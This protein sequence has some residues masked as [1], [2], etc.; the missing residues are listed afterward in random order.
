MVDI[1]FVP[2]EAWHI[3]HVA[4]HMRAEDVHEVWEMGG[5]TPREALDHSLNHHGKAWT[6]LF[7]GVPAAIFG[8]IPLSILSNAAIA[9]L[10]GTDALA[11]HWRA[12]ARV[13]VDVLAEVHA[14]YPVLANAT[15]VENTLAVRWLR[16]LGARIEIHGH[17]ARFLLCA[18]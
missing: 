6:A 16:W 5:F 2:V 11:K 7:D 13:S 12:F 17:E 15:R 1:R 8:V 4:E 3:Q 14:R 18:Q 10:L 9:W